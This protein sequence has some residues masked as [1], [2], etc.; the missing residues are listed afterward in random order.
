MT[1]IHLAW[2]HKIRRDLV[3]VLARTG[4]LGSH[5]TLIETERRSNGLERTALAKR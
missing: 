4:L 3:A 1:E 2:W 5:G